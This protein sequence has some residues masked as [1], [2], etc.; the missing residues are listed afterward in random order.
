MQVATREEI[1]ITLKEITDLLEVQHSK[2]M[3][4][5]EELSKEP[6]FGVLSKMDTI[7]LNGLK[8][9]TYG[10]T[11]IQAI[12]VGARLNN[13]LLMRVVIKLEEPKPQKQMTHLET[14]KM[15]VQSLEKVELLENRVEN[16]RNVIIAATDLNIK[17][18][19]VTIAQFC[20]NIVAKDMGRT[21]LFKWLKDK[22]VLQLNNDPYQAIVDRGY[23]VLRPSKEKIN[24]KYRYTTMLTA[25]GTLWLA[26]QLRLAGFE[27][28]CGGR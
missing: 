4:K 3:K 12:A 16:Q 7:N 26:K 9:E 5:V 19:E 15:L 11:K 17:S 8:L 14:A 21:N 6:N 27:I 23:M 28:T 24:G 2:A 13:T 1:V 25:K 20:K 18:G 10:F 22:K